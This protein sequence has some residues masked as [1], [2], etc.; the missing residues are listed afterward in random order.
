MGSIMKRIASFLIG[1]ALL[2]AG[3]DIAQ[4]KDAN[5]WDILGV[6]LG[7][8]QA[9]TTAILAKQI[10]G[11]NITNNFG[12]LELPNASPK[13]I[14]FSFKASN[15]NTYRKAGVGEENI[16]AVFGQPSGNLI[17]FRRVHSFT[18]ANNTPLPSVSSVK[19]SLTE[20][21]GSPDQDQFI[22][23]DLGIYLFWFKNK[24]QEELKK[25]TFRVYRETNRPGRNV[26]G[27]ANR[28]VWSMA[29]GYF[30]DGNCGIA[31]PFAGIGT[32]MHVKLETDREQ[33]VVRHM[34]QELVNYQMAIE[35][36]N[37]NVGELKAASE[38]QEAEKK[39]KSDKVKPRL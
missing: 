33:T 29:E 14:L 6:K 24:P 20:K 28:Q 8:T 27:D 9:E 15:E 38:A 19:Q 34:L 22:Y 35:S 37:Y 7:M 4:A 18:Q 21:Y 3:I 30:S 13:K 39:S 11:V 36:C 31:T 26:I 1:F 16:I 5:D 25:G 32:I 2:V 12:S 10:P 17:A 23:F